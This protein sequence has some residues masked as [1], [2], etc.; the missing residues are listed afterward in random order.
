MAG[1]SAV[2]S[3]QEA[4]PE[5]LHRGGTP[6]SQASAPSTPNPRSR[7]AVGVHVPHTHLHPLVPPSH[8]VAQLRR[9]TEEGREEPSSSSFTPRTPTIYP[10][11]PGGRS[12]QERDEEKGEDK[13][14]SSGSRGQTEE[15]LVVVDNMNIDSP[16]LSSF[17]FPL[18]PVRFGLPA[19]TPPP[20]PFPTPILSAEDPIGDA[21]TTVFQAL[22][23][24]QIVSRGGPDHTPLTSEGWYEYTLGTLMFG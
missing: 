19:P 15:G 7:M 9:E 11:H 6:G 17:E 10:Q 20:P 4:V 1:P 18:L 5:G 3:V 14:E 23:G 12:S 2:P 8:Q 24:G 16:P 22:A 21:L 13:R